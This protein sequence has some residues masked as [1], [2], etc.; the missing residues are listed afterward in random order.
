MAEAG[1]SYTYFVT[2]LDIAANESEYSQG[3]QHLFTSVHQMDEPSELPVTIR[4][5][6]VYPNP[7]NSSVLFA[8]DLATDTYAMIDVY[9]VLGQHVAEAFSGHLSAGH[10]LIPWSASGIQ[11]THLSSGI[12]FARLST[13]GRGPISTIKVVLMR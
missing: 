6:G 8:V 5:D 4:L 13:P 7:C 11:G 12:V 2:A 9:N 10:H 1:R 3:V